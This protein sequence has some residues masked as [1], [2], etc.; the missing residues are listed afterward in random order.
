MTKEEYMRYALNLAEQSRGR[1]SPNPLVGAVIVKGG[2]IIGE[3]WHKKYGGNHAEINA[4]EDAARAGHDV[5]GAE[6]Y[7]TLEP[8]SHYGK[9]P[10]CARAIIEKKV[11]KVYIGM[12]DPNPL[13]AGQ[14]IKMMEDAGIQVESGIL[15][16]ECRSLN[17]IFLKYIME[18][19]PFVVMKTAMTLDGKI[20]ARTGDSK[21][22]SGE[23]SRSLVQEMR[24]SLTGIMVG[25]GTVL[26]DD[27]R[28][29]CRKEGG[30]DPVRIIVDSHLKI[31]LS[32]KVLQDDN[33]IL[34]ATSDCDPEKKKRL[35]DR[36]LLT[37]SRDGQVDLDDL[38]MQLGKRGID[39]ILLEGG[40][41]LNES[42]LKAG[43]VDRVIFFIAPKI[44]GGKDAPTPVEGE[45]LARMDE[46]ISLD[47]VQFE[48]IGEDLMIQAIPK[49]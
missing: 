14:G 28:L 47:N 35:G 3:G 21:W 10:P 8:C 11:K 33:Y 13:V 41:R 44:I 4:F 12:E 31:P 32:A 30:R 42:A 15:E 29:T 25:I 2:R 17:E 1:T 34:A 48:K 7:V 36:V 23:E 38:M 19:R 43:I 22:V 24:N 20:A 37:K 39:S 5:Q 6:M 45:G 40:G 49:R 26:A 46:A 9:T 27:P 16:K 18:K